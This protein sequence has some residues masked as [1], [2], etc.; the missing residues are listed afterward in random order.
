[1]QRE[2]TM[3]RK[4]LLMGVVLLALSGFILG[5]GSARAADTER[6]AVYHC[7]FGNPKRVDAMLRNIYNLVNFYTT[8][9]IS[10]DVRVVSNSACVQ[11]LL[12]DT[13]GTKFASKKIP[14][15]LAKSIKE[16]MQS[17]AD[18]YD[19]KFEQCSITLKRTNTPKSKLKPFVAIVN[20]GQVRVVELQDKGYAYIKVK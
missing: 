18:G 5:P 2:V 3:A 20:S 17:L 11:F 16:R 7:D 9:G 10:Y 19:V 1:M 15:K 8:N 12:T 14:P 6:K 4:T 13:K